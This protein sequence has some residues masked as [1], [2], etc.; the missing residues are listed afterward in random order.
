LIADLAPAISRCFPRFPGRTATRSATR[1][2]SSEPK[3][4]A[5]RTRRSWAT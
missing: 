3:P 5:D 4:S 1:R 2:L